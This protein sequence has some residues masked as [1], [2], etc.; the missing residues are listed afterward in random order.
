MTVLND[1]DDDDLRQLFRVTL[2]LYREERQ[3][4]KEEKEEEKRRK[5]EEKLKLAELKRR[6]K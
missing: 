6:Q 3:K 5:E 2:Y 1:Q 4:R